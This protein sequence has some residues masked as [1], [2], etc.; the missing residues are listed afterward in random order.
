M[1]SRT[2]V[3]PRRRPASER[4]RPSPL[5]A[6][7]RQTTVAMRSVSAPGPVREP[8]LGVAGGARR[9]DRPIRSTPAAVQGGAEHR[10]RGRGPGCPAR[11]STG[12]RGRSGRPAGRGRRRRTRSTPGRCRARSTA[13]IDPAPSPSMAVDG[14]PDHPGLEAPPAGVGGA[15]HAVGAAE[16]DRHAV[17]GLDGQGH[18]RLGRDQRVGLGA[19]RPSAAFVARSPRPR[20][21]RGPGAATPTAG[22]RPPRAGPP[23]PAGSASMAKSPS[24]RVRGVVQDDARHGRPRRPTVRHA[25]SGSEATRAT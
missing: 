22:R 7:S 13:V 4:S 10:R 19:G 6:G 23:G 21:R 8:A 25:A 15:D 24:A 20:R 3:E 16:D 1:R 17:G 9:P 5:D 2:A 12:P 14:A 11:S 18:A